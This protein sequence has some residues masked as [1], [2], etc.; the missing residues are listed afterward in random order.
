MIECKPDYIESM[1]KSLKSISIMDTESLFTSDYL[2]KFIDRQHELE[3]IEKELA[4]AKL[5]H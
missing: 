3:Q 1:C 5:A 4:A 2:K